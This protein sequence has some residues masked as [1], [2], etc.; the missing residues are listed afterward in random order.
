MSEILIQ[1]VDVVLTMDDQRRKLEGADIRLKDGV[2]AE[3]G[4]QLETHGSIVNGRGS[5][6]TPGLIN[7]H[8][9]LYQNLTR[10]VP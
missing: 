8:H 9:H 1:S 6:V 2:I 5:V 10:A 7:T 3:I 4:T